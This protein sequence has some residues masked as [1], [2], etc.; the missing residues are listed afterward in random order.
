AEKSSLAFYLNECG[1]KSKLDMP[2][3]CI[4]KYYRNVLK[5]AD[6]TTAKQMR[7]IAKYCIVDA[8]SCQWLMIKCNVINKYRE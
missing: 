4:F 1:L 5:K 3:N 2:F 7:E 8:L 6:A